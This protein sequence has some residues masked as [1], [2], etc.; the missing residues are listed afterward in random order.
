MNTFTFD[1]GGGHSSSFVK[2]SVSADIR[3]LPVS[4]ED[5][6]YF[7]IVFRQFVCNRLYSVVRLVKELASRSWTREQEVN[8]ILKTLKARLQDIRIGVD[9][10]LNETVPLDWLRNEHE[11]RP[12]TVED[13]LRKL[14]QDAS[15]KK[16]HE[17]PPSI[18][19]VPR[20]KDTIVYVV[21]DLEGQ[22]H[23]LMNFLIDKRLV[24]LKTR[25][26]DKE[27]YAE[28]KGD[29][30]VYVV[31]VGDQAD[32]SRFKDTYT[33]DLM[34]P[35]WTD[36]LE[37]VSGGHIT[38]INGNHEWLNSP[39]A[40]KDDHQSH[41]YFA[42]VHSSNAVK[43]NSESFDKNSL[44]SGNLSGNE[45]RKY[46]PNRLKL[47]EETGPVG[48]ILFRR[49]YVIAI[50]N[51]LFSHAGIRT[52]DIKKVAFSKRPA[53]LDASNVLI[54]TTLDRVNAIPFGEAI[55]MLQNRNYEFVSTE[56]TLKYYN[57]YDKTPKAVY[58]FTEHFPDSLLTGANLMVTG[59]NKVSSIS[60]SCE[61]SCENE[62]VDRGLENYRLQKNTRFVIGVDNV[63][64]TAMNSGSI[65]ILCMILKD[66]NRDDELTAI[67]RDIPKNTND[68]YDEDR[69]LQILQEQPG[70]TQPA[71]GSAPPSSRGKQQT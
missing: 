34:V 71:S 68:K 11:L 18:V 31:Q 61:L 25:D 21:G 7:Y 65:E 49:N 20:D 52:K 5:H 43:T 63:T 54:S 24:E 53:R 14:K 32:A 42:F 60:L 64:E 13:H 67:V 69:I 30:N 16:P 19:D 47:L 62:V 45:V 36:Y 2:F 15:D 27:R 33:F 22:L 51:A 50:R 8:E 66:A 3:K 40:K 57:R 55:E 35:I 26:D 38:S 39:H 4:P 46:L 10:R 17:K 59:H 70:Q 56:G 37:V 44:E 48:R 12:Y 23:I 28:W 9:K 1:F 41:P 6:P 29:S 58:M